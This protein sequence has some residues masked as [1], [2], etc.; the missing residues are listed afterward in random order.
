MKHRILSLLVLLTAAFGS[1]MAGEVSYDAGAKAYREGK[2]AEAAE[3]WSRLAEE[4]GT[5]ADLYYDIGNAYCAEGDLGHARLYYE[6]ANRLAPGN[7]PMATNLRYV[8]SKVDDAN[9]ATMQGKRGTVVPDDPGFLQTVHQNVARDHTSDYWALYALF[10]FLLLLGAIALYLF[11]SNVAARKT[12]F[13]TAIIFLFFSVVFVTFSVMAR[14]AAESH[15]FG[16][17]TAY[18]IELLTEPSS[19]SKPS[20]SPLTQGTKV[21]LLTEESDVEGNVA[22]YKV[23]LNSNY[24]GWIPASDLEVI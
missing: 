10:S 15:D 13:F 20:A 5:S 14:N 11:P 16:V 4:T 22:W 12:G 17:I 1:L 23:R 2:Y 18:K 19:G 3:I 7:E 6:R 21:K 9:K 24:V 8:I